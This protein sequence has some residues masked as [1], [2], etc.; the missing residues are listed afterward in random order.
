MLPGKRDDLFH[1]GRGDVFWKDTAQSYAF[2]MD[3]EHD[4]CGTFAVHGEKFL[5]HDDHEVHRSEIVIEQKYLKERGRFYPRPLC[6]KHEVFLPL[7][8]H[9]F[10]SNPRPARRNC[11]A[12]HGSWQECLHTRAFGYCAAPLRQHF[13]V[14]VEEVLAEV[15]LWRL[16]ARKLLLCNKKLLA[17]FV[18]AQYPSA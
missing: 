1:F 12:W 13:E 10:H 2:L 8:S 5:Q 15:S 7:C 4:P 17:F 14:K 3:L 16:G 9:A 11:A 18:D 6:L